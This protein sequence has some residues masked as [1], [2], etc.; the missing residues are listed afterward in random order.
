M[1]WLQGAQAQQPA[2]VH[3]VLKLDVAVDVQTVTIGIDS[4][5][6]NIVGFER[7]PRTDAER[8]AAQQAV[9]QLRAADKLFDI[10]AAAGCKLSQV[11][12]EAPSLSLGQA[13]T[14]SAQGHAE[15]EGSFIFECTR[16]VQ[17]R[18]IDL[19]L[20]DV[21]RNVRQIDVQI[22]TPEGQYQRTLK[23]PAKRLAWGK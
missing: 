8:K 15:L 7:A 6:D 1:L 18:F 14:P 12:L 9:A 17:T 4:P 2:H 3:G 22:V 10:D 20:F 21:F 19:A 13:A 11:D 5:L 16:A 23:R